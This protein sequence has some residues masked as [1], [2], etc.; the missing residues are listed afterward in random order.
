MNALKK[1]IPRYDSPFS[2]RSEHNPSL[3]PR[4]S[5][6]PSPLCHSILPLISPPFSFS[7]RRWRARRANPETI[8]HTM[9]GKEM[10]AIL[11]VGVEQ[12]EP[13]PLLTPCY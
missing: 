9:A 4:F 10:Q 8:F 2:I 12:M 13:T 5:L 11:E 1:Q 3:S 7:P 6:S